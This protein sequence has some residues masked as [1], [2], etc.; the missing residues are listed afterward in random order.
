MTSSKFNIPNITRRKVLKTSV[1]VIS[2]ALLLT[3]VD[4]AWGA[5]ILGGAYLAIG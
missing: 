2:F 3:E 5:K 1:K 4:I